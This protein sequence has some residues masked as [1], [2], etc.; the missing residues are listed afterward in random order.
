MTEDQRQEYLR[1]LMHTP[2]LT[3]EQRMWS[4]DAFMA[5]PVKRQSKRQTW[6]EVLHGTALGFVGSYAITFAVLRLCPG[7]VELK[8]AITVA[9]CTVWSLVRGYGVRRYHN[10][11]I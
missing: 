11:K 2:E 6:V 9:G 4:L 1:W 8:S 10:R 5:M 7:S 3:T